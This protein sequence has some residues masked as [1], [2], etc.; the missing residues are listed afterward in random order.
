MKFSPYIPIWR[1]DLNQLRPVKVTADIENRQDSEGCLISEYSHWNSEAE[2]WQAISDRLAANFAASQSHLHYVEQ[3]L[4]AAH[5]EIA[6][7]R[8]KYSRFLMNREHAKQEQ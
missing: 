3:R 6:V 5:K 8:E 7:Y 2:A 1:A 4:T